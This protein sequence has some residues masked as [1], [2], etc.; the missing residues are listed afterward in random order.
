MTVA[1]VTFANGGNN[2]GVYVPAFPSVGSAATAAYCLA[3]LVLVAL[4]KFAATRPAIAEILQRWEHVLFP[5][6]LVGL[7]IVI[8]SSDG[9]FGL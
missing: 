5:V 2:I 6:V 8:L 1:A 7:G 3:F 9:A 4:T